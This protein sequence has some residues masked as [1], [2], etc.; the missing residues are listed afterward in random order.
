MNKQKLRNR[1]LSETHPEIAKQFHLKKNSGISPSSISGSYTKSVVWLCER[2]HEWTS[3][4]RGRVKSLQ[5]CKMCDSLAFTHPELIKEWHPEKNGQLTPL[6]F[7]AGS[8][9]IVWWVCSNG[10]VWS[11]EIRRRVEGLECQICN[12]RRASLSNS[13]SVSHPN[14]AAEWDYEKKSGF[15]YKSNDYYINM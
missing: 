5:N 14:I 2:G 9:K 4:P 8:H 12:N 11:S 7:K 15:G 13:L 6:N 10:H 3:T 1:P